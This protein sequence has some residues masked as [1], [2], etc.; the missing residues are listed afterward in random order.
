M[1]D[2]I[3]VLCLH[4]CSRESVKCNAAAAAVVVLKIIRQTNLNACTKW[5]QRWPRWWRRIV[6][7]VLA[8]ARYA[9]A[10]KDSS[11][12]PSGR[13]AISTTPK[14]NILNISISIIN[15]GAVSTKKPTNTKSPQNDTNLTFSSFEHDYHRSFNAK[16]TPF[17][18]KASHFG[19]LQL[20][21]FYAKENGCVW[22]EPKT[23]N[24]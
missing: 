7:K 1:R 9:N 3:D 20:K 24:H 4:W 13:T 22:S 5:R 17:L 8:L 18:L 21:S 15:S 2:E 19:I 16:V 14:G 6:G 23:R 12:S 10:A 11:Y